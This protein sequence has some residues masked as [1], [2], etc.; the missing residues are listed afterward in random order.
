MSDRFPPPDWF[1]RQNPWAPWMPSTA[2]NGAPTSPATAPTSSML[3]TSISNRDDS[4][5]FHPGGFNWV[6]TPNG[7][8]LAVHP[9]G[10]GVDWVET[11]SGGLLAYPKRQVQPAWTPSAIP[12]HLGSARYLGAAPSPTSA[13]PASGRAPHLSPVPQA[14]IWDQVSTTGRATADAVDTNRRNPQVLDDTA[15]LQNEPNANERVASSFGELVD[16][17]TAAAA[18]TRQPVQPE[19]GRRDGLATRVAENIGKDIGAAALNLATLPQRAMHAADVFER[20]GDYDPA[21]IVEAATLMVGSPLTPRGA[22]GSAARQPGRPARL[23]MDEASRMERAETMG[24][25]RDMPIEYGLAPEG[26]KIVAAAVNVNGHVFT[27]ANHTEAMLTAERQLGIPFAQMQMAPIMDGFIT[28]SGRYV[29]RWEAGDVARRAGQGEARGAFGVTRGL[30]AED[31]K[32][33]ADVAPS[34]KI[35]TGAT[36]PGLPG[37]EGVWGWV[38]PESAASGPTSPLWRQTTRPAAMD[39]QVEAGASAQTSP[40]WHRTQQPV[41]MDAR[42]AA[43]HEIRASLREAWEQGYDAVLLKNYT[44]PS[45]KSGDVLVV[46]DPV[47]LRDPKARFNPAKRN[48]ANLLA[49]GA[50]AAMVGPTRADLLGER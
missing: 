7:G 3:P 1:L 21:P 49:S 33:A 40:L 43:D 42:G 15:A 39:A 26:E 20:G 19:G 11:P 38:L 10:E 30:A 17:F 36:A 22:L 35:R 25:R 31:T 8:L 4:L 28:T 32:M 41:R 2:S 12:E 24:F 45:G 46:R 5:S 34:T 27:G 50:G 47:Q 18:R 23:P 29:S 44:S 37:G 16:P 14:P 13:E 9:N 6:E 48:S